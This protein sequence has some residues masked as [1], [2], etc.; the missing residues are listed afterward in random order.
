MKTTFLAILAFFTSIITF[1]QTDNRITI[2]TIDSIQST[3]LNEERK[4]WVYVPHKGT[5]NPILAAQKYPV[6]YLLDGNQHFS[7]VV[8]MIQQLGQANNN[9]MVPEM[10]VVGIPNTNR[11][12]DLTPTK[13]GDDPFMEVR[14]MSFEEAGGGE[15]FM[16]FIE[17]ELIPHIEK[18]YPT[19]PYKTLVGHSF[20]GLTVMNALINHTELFDSYIAIDPSMWW[21]NLKF[22]ET[23]KE[24]MTQKDFSESTL[25]LSIAN[26]MDEGMTIR[27]ALKDTTFAT[28]GIRA[29]LE[30]DNFIKTQQPKGLK[31]ASKYYENDTHN[32]VTLISTY[33][34]FR[35]IFDKYELII[36]NDDIL[37][38]NSAFADKIQKRY[39]DISEIFGYEVKPSEREI[40]SWG[41]RFLQREQFSKAEDFF[42]L[43][44]K[45]YPESFNVYDSYGE[46]FVAAGEKVKAIEQF[47]KALT[48]KDDPATREKLNKLL[49]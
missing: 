25:Y 21:D 33:D 40:N 49:E 22:L 28:H 17:K 47:E 10:I 11:S 44:I 48:V 4:I 12:R 39:E 30:M 41:Y 6:V 43:N 7:S 1:G 2:G 45:L 31:Y 5:T 36:D 15:A 42:K 14:G 13:P 18:N 27:E 38:P 20:G 34:A 8:G 35:F 32:G 26:T 29:A 23:A 19:Q 9:T 16:S 37:D 3:I 24:A 46:Y